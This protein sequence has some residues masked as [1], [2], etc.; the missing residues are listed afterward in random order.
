[1]I[2]FTASG[3]QTGELSGIPPTGRSVSADVCNVVEVRDGKIYREREYYDVMG[4]MQQLGVA[5]AAS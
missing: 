3:T 5:P 2:E 1:V 4:L